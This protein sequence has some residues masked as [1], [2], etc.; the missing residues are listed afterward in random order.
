MHGRQTRIGVFARDQ[1][2]KQLV[3]EKLNVHRS[4]E[5]IAGWVR[6]EHPDRPGWHVCHETI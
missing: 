4:P 5:Q 2:L 3:Q 6:T 1:Q